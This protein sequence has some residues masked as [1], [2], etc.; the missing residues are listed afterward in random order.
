MDELSGSFPATEIIGIISLLFF[1][2]FFSGAETALT[3]L[4][5]TRVR[6][7]LESQ[8]KRY[9]IFEFWLKYKKRILT[10]LLVGNNLVNIF[11]SILAY[12][13]ALYFLPSYAEAVSVFGLTIIILIFS[14]I[15]PKNLA[16]YYSEI[17]AVPVLRITWFVDKLLWVV[18]TPLARIP[19]LILRK[20]GRLVDG[21]MVTEDEIEY[22][23]RLGHDQA[24]FEEEAQG[25]LL[26]SA[27]EFSE[28]SVKEVMIPR[29]DIFGLDVT[30]PMAR[31]VDAVIKSGHSRIPVFKSNLDAII[32]LLHAKDLL[33]NLKTRGASTLSNIETIV[34]KPLMFAPETQKISDLLA[35]MRRRGKHMAIVVDEF[36]GTSG[37]ITLEDIIEELV[38]D[39]RDEFD[40]YEAPVRRIDDETWIVD[41][42]LSIHDLK[43]ATGIE[44]PDSGDYESVGGFVVA[45]NGIIPM[46]GTVVTTEQ[47][48]AKVLMSDDRHIERLEVKLTPVESS[49]DDE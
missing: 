25:D 47:I 41:A 31:A 15:T 44:L 40:P 17:I 8:P 46:T 33:G 19:E 32:G 43:D 11:C 7:L 1:S 39:I 14:E 42:R 26:M 3:H 5:E 13:V 18:S 34:R 21:L 29:T 10:C 2:A 22:Q 4:P 35:K 48:Q 16:L 27:V 36:G 38:G 49:S 24:V 23:I 30:T 37:L 6:Q 12:R 45:E 28:I 20:S 9:G